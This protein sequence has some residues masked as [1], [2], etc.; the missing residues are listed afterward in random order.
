MMKFRRYKSLA[1]PTEPIEGGCNASNHNLALL[2]EIDA[3]GLSRTT[4]LICDADGELHKVPD[5]RTKRLTE[6][7]K[8]QIQLEYQVF[9]DV[10]HSKRLFDNNIPLT[11]EQA[12]VFRETLK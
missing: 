3:L 12:E 8:Q 10:D 5:W 9:F 6:K 11:K 2:D 1:V 4:A 7:E